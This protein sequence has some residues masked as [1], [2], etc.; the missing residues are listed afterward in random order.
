MSE[1]VKE[2]LSKEEYEKVGEMLLELIAAC[3]HIPEDLKDRAGG[4]KYQSM[5]T[6]TC[7]GIL[8]LPGAKYVSFDISGGFTAQV[9][10]QIAYK[11]FPTTNAQNINAQAVVDSIMDW[12]ENVESL[13]KLSGGRTITKITASN[14]FASVDEVGDDKSTVFVADAV[15][16]YR[17]KGV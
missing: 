5:S 7:I 6:E 13:P 1:E 9:N 11:S 14:S 16:Q 17:K 15:M 2:R 8:T 12:L 4:I 10:F 3:P